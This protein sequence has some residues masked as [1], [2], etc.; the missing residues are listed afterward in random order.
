VFTHV[1]FF[2]TF[3][4]IYNRM[5]VKQ[6]N[7]EKALATG[8]CVLRRT[9]PNLNAKS[10]SQI[11]CQFQQLV[12]VPSEG[13]SSAL[14]A[15]AQN[16]TGMG[17]NRPTTI[18]SVSEEVCKQLGLPVEEDFFDP[19]PDFEGGGDDLS[20]AVLANKIFESV[21]K[22]K[23]INIKVTENFTPNPFSKTHEPKMNPRTN[24]IL[25]KDGQPI[26][27]HTELVEGE[28]DHTFVAHDRIPTGV[29][30]EG[31][32]A[33]LSGAISGQPE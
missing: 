7:Y 4:F 9:W 26:Y 21:R 14:I 5:E 28:A 6:S 16:I 31:L 13:T 18:F 12:K 11:S 15:F 23:D 19:G 32:G 20:K 33:L 3:L 27:R 22:G 29:P 24:E 1:Y 8:A 2:Y 10:G 17:E 25:M 30:A